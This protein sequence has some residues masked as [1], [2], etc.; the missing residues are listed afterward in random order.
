MRTSVFCAAAL[1]GLANQ[2]VLA[3]E[4]RLE[5]VAATMPELAVEVFAAPGEIM[6]RTG[7][8]RR[9]E[10]VSYSEENV[11]GNGMLNNYHIE[12][13][14]YP[15]MRE[16]DEA[17]Y[18]E[19]AWIVR[20]GPIAAI[21][22]DRQVASLDHVPSSFKT[23]KEESRTCVRTGLYRMNVCDTE[24]EYIRE[25]RTYF[26][27]VKQQHALHFDGLDGD[28]VR[29]TYRRMGTDPVNPVAFAQIRH[30]LSESDI[31]EFAGARLRSVETAED[32]V[33]YEVLEGFGAAQ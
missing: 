13:G 18:H 12:P 29:L 2:P 15:V 8:A 5:R 20:D 31:I 25:T 14:F 23:S 33:F 11:I 30:D 10:G 1:A 28:T 19:R 22:K 17:T 7:M 16:D 32:G 6:L 21:A 4:N 9:G 24:H 3:Q 27:D 26:V